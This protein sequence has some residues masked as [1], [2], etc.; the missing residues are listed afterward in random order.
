MRDFAGVS[1]NDSASA[2]EMPPRTPAQVR[3][4]A[5]ARESMRVQANRIGCTPA[6]TNL[7]NRTIGTAAVATRRVLGSKRRIS[8]AR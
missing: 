1:G 5:L 2:T 3:N 4:G 8:V 6:K 7:V